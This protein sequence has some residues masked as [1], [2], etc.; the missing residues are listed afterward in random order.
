MTSATG[1]TGNPRLI[2]RFLNALS[3]RMAMSRAQG[4][5]VDESVLAK[6]LLF[7]R[8]GDPKA[9]AALIKSVMDSDQGK[10]VFL[11]DWE[12]GAIHGESLALKAPWDEPFITDWLRLPP[13]LG[14]RDLRGVLYVSRE[15]MPLIMPEDSLSSETVELLWA[16]LEHP[17][18]AGSV[19][20]RLG[21]V[22]SRQHIPIAPTG[23]FSMPDA[24]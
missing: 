23:R 19:K 15:H 21:A 14:D 6:V 3:I 22:E 9:Y 24:A 13:Q 1:I 8:C 5:G 11:A 17:D 20:D 7:E 12:R 18:M 2:K 10:P 4:V 16:L